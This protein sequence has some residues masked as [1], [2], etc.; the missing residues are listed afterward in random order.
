MQHSV[1]KWYNQQKGEREC[2][3][4]KKIWTLRHWSHVFQRV[5]RLLKS[6]QVPIGAKVLFLVP[7]V[8]YWAFP[9]LLP[10]MP[11][12]DIAVT[13]ILANVFSA[14]LERKYPE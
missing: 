2:G 7:V 13:M 4:M 5:F 6:R 10:F 14:A 3:S 11:V 12:D 1:E 9:D 8:L